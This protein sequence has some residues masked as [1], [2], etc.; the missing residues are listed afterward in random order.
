MLL[1]AETTAPLLFPVVELTSTSED[2]LP[3]SHDELSFFDGLG[4][5]EL[6]DVL[7]M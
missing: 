4:P 2:C 5:E 7:L 1:R 6:S 3:T